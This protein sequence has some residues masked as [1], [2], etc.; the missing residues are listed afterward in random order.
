MYHPRRRDIED[1][2]NQIRELESQ[3]ALLWDLVDSLKSAGRDASKAA[4]GLAMLLAMRGQAT[5]ARDAAVRAEATD[6]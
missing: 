2:D 4:L 5:I 6:R 3:I 1:L